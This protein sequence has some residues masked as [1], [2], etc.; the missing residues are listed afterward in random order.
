MEQYEVYYKDIFLG[1]LKVDTTADMYEYTPDMEAVQLVKEEVFLIPEMTEGTNGFVA[2]IP[3]FQNRIRN[4]KRSGLK[5]LRYHTD[6]FGMI[7]CDQL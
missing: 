5:K 4:M 7:R 1:T 3:F 2:P 6:W